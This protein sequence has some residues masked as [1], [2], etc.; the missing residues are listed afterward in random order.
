VA[1]S[2]TSFFLS[3]FWCVCRLCDLIFV[4]D[5]RVI[6]WVYHLELLCTKNHCAKYMGREQ[7]NRYAKPRPLFS[8]AHK[9]EHD[10]RSGEG[11]PGSRR[12]DEP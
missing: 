8:Q 6:S 4:C 9:H 2:G 7:K 3:F 5:R 12:S 1:K 11:W 10:T